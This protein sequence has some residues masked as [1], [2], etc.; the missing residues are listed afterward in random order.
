M[1]LKKEVTVI[2]IILVFMLAVFLVNNPGI[3][4]LTVL[5]ETSI[6]I[7]NARLK[8]NELNTNYANI[9]NV[10]AVQ[11]DSSKLDEFQS[12][13]NS[14]E[15][16]DKE[17]GAKLIKAELESL[18]DPLPKKISKI[19]T[20]RDSQILEPKDV[21]YSY[22]LS[23][24]EELYLYQKKF[25]VVFEASKYD[26]ES[27]SGSKARYTII[28]KII[29]NAEN[30]NE[31]FVYELLPISKDAVNFNNKA[32]TLEGNAAKYE[33]SYAGNIEITYSINQDIDVTNI[34]GFKTI[35]VPKAQASIITT[36]EAKLYTC[37]DS[38][39][40]LPYED[41]I[42]CPEDCIARGKKIPWPYIITL[43]IILLL[44]ISYLNLY[45]GKGDFRKLSRGKTPFASNVDMENVKN[46][47]KN[48]IN[49]NVKMKDISKA[50]LAK[51]WNKRQIEYAFEEARWDLKKILLETAPKLNLGNV[52]A[53]EE[54]ARKCVSLGMDELKIKTALFSK[55][56]KP[57][58]I[59]KA[60]KK[61]KSDG[62]R[63][64]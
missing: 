44:G 40:T 15:G 51:G 18:L 13:L 50:L 33:F 60:L 58:Q 2:V 21:K 55:G 14:L 29:T 48:S 45:R 42:I 46:F 35:I 34:Y 8:F 1:K 6:I 43:I 16:K 24:S 53:A 31:F 41:E 11:L 23:S 27:Y 56:W 36:E 61:A 5:D 54:Y 3:T 10:M 59:D 12:R 22:T 37:G 39:C 52:T 4:S 7:E 32:Y 47:I 20:L 64:F 38:T 26:I 49:K 25:N 17:D 30:I 63:Y 28:K 57:E 62:H 9:L 19:S